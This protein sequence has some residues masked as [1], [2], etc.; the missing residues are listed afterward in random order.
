MLIDKATRMSYNHKKDISVVFCLS[1]GGV[2]MKFLLRSFEKEDAQNIAKSADNPNIAK[3]LRNSFP[4]PYT[5][6]DANWYIN[7]CICK[8]GKKQ[9]VRAISVDEKAVGTIGIFVKEDV[10]E[11]SA[12][13]GYWLSQD[14]W[15]N[16]IMT[17]AVKIICR[18]AFSK[19]DIVRIFAEPFECNA[20]SRKV[21]E[22][23]GFT[24]EGTMRNGIYK[25]GN[26][27]SYC[28][29]SVLREEM[30]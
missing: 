17:E 30:D 19:F 20:A 16:G 27:C 23:A 14:Y 12:E 3:Y 18:E 29:Y 11:K 21:L 10:L 24:Y 22:K 7:D 28:V 25:N 6:E 2:F 15:N 26:I 9:I 5:L 8:E 13:L 4:N 1:Y